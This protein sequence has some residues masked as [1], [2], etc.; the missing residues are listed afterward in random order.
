MN[1]FPIG[2]SQ[3]NIFSRFVSCRLFATQILIQP[4]STDDYMMSFA[5]LLRIENIKT[6]PTSSSMVCS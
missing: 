2:K 3:K 5:S 1:R 4:F 6:T